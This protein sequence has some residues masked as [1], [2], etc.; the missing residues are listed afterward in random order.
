MAFADII[1][2]FLAVYQDDLTTYSKKEADHCMHLEVVFVR[3]LKFGIS[4]NPRKCAFAITE[5]KL[6]G[7]LVGQD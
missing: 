6:L 2:D 1:N 4:L 7:H 5:G 3:A